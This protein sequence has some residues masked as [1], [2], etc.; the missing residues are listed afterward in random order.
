[1][2]R[3]IDDHIVACHFAE[4][5]KAGKIVPDEREIVFDPGIQAPVAELPPD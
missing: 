5:I 1:M 4:E 2:L 3:P